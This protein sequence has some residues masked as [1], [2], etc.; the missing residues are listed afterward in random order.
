MPQVITKK[1]KSSNRAK[2]FPSKIGADAPHSERTVFAALAALPA[3]WRVFYSV[4]WQSTR[5]RAGDEGL[6]HLSSCLFLP[7]KGHLSR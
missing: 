3:E 5:G 4:A 2:M 1:Q 7:G 6:A